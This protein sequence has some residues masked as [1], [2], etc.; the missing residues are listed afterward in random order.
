MD[1]LNEALNEK[2]EIYTLIENRYIYS[3]L[4]PETVGELVAYHYGIATVQSCVFYLCGLHENYFIQTNKDKYFV[5]IYRNDWRNPEEINFELELLNY[6]KEKKEPVSSPLETKTNKLLFEVGSPEGEKIGALF[7]YVEGEPLKQEITINESKL[8]GRSVASIHNQTKDF[9]TEYKRKNLDLEYLVKRSLKV[10]EPFLTIEQKN[11]LTL[12]QEKIE[13]KIS[14]LVTEKTELVA[15]TGDVN[16]RNFHITKNNKI[17][18]FDFDQCGYGQRAFEIGKFFSSQHFHKSKKEIT[19]AFLQGYE[20]V[21]K[22]SIEE[23]KAIHYFEIASVLWVMSIRV[24]NVNKV[25]H[26]TLGSEYW[27]QRIG[28]IE[29]LQASNKHF[30][31]TG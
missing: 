29:E 13:T 25:G 24:D 11:Y 26:M 4:S 7:T 8:L 28:I 3:R 9:T 23:K 16:T 31:L 21:Y 1:R 14:Q 15:C 2:G 30:N 10:I 17:T 12:V 20:S 6:L 5:R 27:V 22:L 18:L 19:Q